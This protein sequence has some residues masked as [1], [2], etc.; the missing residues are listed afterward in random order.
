MGPPKFGAITFAG[1]DM[2]HPKIAYPRLR[3][4]F[5]SGELGADVRFAGKRFRLR[6]KFIRIVA[7]SAGKEE[8]FQFV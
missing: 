2:R 1:S 7:A 8:A 3:Y 5:G 4:I 6:Q